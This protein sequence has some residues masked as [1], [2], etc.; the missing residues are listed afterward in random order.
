MR[1]IAPARNR[2]NGNSILA[3]R[4]PRAALSGE[5]AAELV[6]FALLLPLL[7]ILV[8]GVMDFGRAF[9]ID[10]A[11]SN[12]SRQGARIAAS[13]TSADVLVP[14]SAPPI[15]VQLACNAVVEYL[16]N[17]NVD[18]SFMPNSGGK[19]SKLTYTGAPS[20]TG[21]D[22]SSASGNPKYCYGFTIERE[23]SVPA[24]GG[25]TIASTR[26][27]LNFPYDWT[28]GFNRMIKFLAPSSNYSPT[29]SVVTNALMENL[30]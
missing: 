20:F 14:G 17:A 3:C 12:A 24:T 5:E 7:L 2:R 23:V 8:L 4:T 13:A 21:T 27:T 26:V 19:C 1:K 10:Q 15:S 6:E 16:Q 29:V 22:C 25:G 18:T 9:Q 28:F 11:L 30:E